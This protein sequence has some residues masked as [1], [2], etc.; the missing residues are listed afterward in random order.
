MNEAMAGDSDARGAAAGGAYARTLMTLAVGLAE[1][2]SVARAKHLPALLLD[3]PA[4]PPPTLR[5]LRAMCRLPLPEGRETEYGFGVV[6]AKTGA[7][8]WGG[9]PLPVS[10]DAATLALGALKDLILERPTAR[11]AALEIVLEAA[12]HADEDVRGR[13]IR[14]VATKLHPTAT[15]TSGVEAF[16]RYHLGE[17]AGAGREKLAKAKALAKKAAEAMRKAAAKK[18]AEEK[19]AA[20]KA[21][22]LRA[23]AEVDPRP[24]RTEPKQ[25]TDPGTM[26]KTTT[27]RT[28][29]NRRLPRASRR[30]RSPPPSPSPRATFFCFAR[31]ALGS[32]NFSPICFERTPNF[33]RNFD[34][35]SWTAQ[36]PSTD[37]SDRWDPRVSL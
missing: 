3:A 21:A 23:E 18:K 19:A 16:A 10:D 14:L 25:K 20:A 34:P 35:R 33:R 22:A 26:T 30:R 12:V 1:S 27:R 2:D 31:C 6:D 4:I 11:A 24:R 36:R 29:R 37:S 7:A 8:S 13:A 5:L 17:A 32:A 9:E 28:S 15:L